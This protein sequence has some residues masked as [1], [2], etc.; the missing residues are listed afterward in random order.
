MAVDIL[1]VAAHADDVEL[2]CAGT[3]VSWKARGG[4]FGIVD[5]TRGEM[6]TRGDPA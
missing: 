1:A 4:R 6:G 5:L 3:L 2:G